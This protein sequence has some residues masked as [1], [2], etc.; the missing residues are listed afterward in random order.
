[1]LDNSYALVKGGVV[2]NIAVWDG[3]Q[4]VDFGAG[5]VPV[6][7]TGEGGNIGDIYEDGKFKPAPLTAE[8]IADNKVINKE[9]NI[10]LKSKLMTDANNQI[11]MLQ[12]AVDFDMATDE[13]QKALPLWK[14][15][16]VILSRVDAATSDEIEWPAIPG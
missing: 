2:V 12:D 6:K 16:R 10:K 15:Y 14:K 13:E 9:I 1:M 3:E 5:I 8:E 11:N 4:S 7:M